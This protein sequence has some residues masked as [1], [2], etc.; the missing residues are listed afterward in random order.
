MSD[1]VWPHG[2]QPTRLL[3]PWDCPGNSTGVGCH[4]LLRLSELWEIKFL[5]FKLTSLWHFIVAVWAKGYNPL[6]YCPGT[7]LPESR[8]EAGVSVTLPYTTEQMWLL[9]CSGC[10]LLKNAELGISKRLLA[11]RRAARWSDSAYCAK[12]SHFQ[13]R[14]HHEEQLQRNSPAKAAGGHCLVAVAGLVTDSKKGTAYVTHTSRDFKH[15]KELIFRKLGFMHQQ[16]GEMSQK[17]W[18]LILVLPH[19]YPESGEASGNYCSTQLTPEQMSMKIY[20]KS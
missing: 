13:K 3:H 15:S 5:W 18:V 19:M 8:T 2:L 20:L 12:L 6:L 10:Y 4:C 17:N 14:L 1:S 16:F 9:E 7:L 11:P